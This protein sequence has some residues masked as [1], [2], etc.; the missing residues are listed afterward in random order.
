MEKGE[1]IIV[2]PAYEPNELLV[3][4]VLKLNQYFD[5]EKIIVVDDG[6]K[7]KET[8]AKIKEFENVILLNH[9]ENRGK[10]AAL[11]TAYQ[12]ILQLKD[13]AHIIVTADAD[14]QHRPEDI[15]KV[16]NYYDEIKEGI[17][18]G[19]RL[20]EKK[21]P[22]R[23]RFGNSVTRF[24]FRLGNSQSLQDNQTGLR[25]FGDEL[26]PFMMEISGNRYEYE[27]NVLMECS[28]KN[29]SIH[30]VKIDTVYINNNASS[31]FHPI[32][33]FFK[34]CHNMIKYALPYI[35]SILCDIALFL[36][37]F[38]SL[39]SL[40]IENKWIVLISCFI[41]CV[42]SAIV[43]LLIH[44]LKIFYGN[45]WLL[46]LPKKRVKYL[47]IIL[48]SI[49]TNSF[50]VFGLYELIDNVIHAKVVGELNLLVGILIFNYILVP[51][52]KLR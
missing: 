14:G 6:S 33:D 51:K 19:S 17:V 1:L 3:D 11:K 41:S 31:H 47:F 13:Q 49:F 10:G 38:Y 39:K 4:L 23:S 25:A 43:N 36:L 12:Y 40:K 30:E 32:K 18:L 15:F 48:A 45:Q 50:M 34:I 44:H 46:K 5:N 9:P 52:P 42:L 22:L 21:V 28:R 24:L 27:M 20:F 16:A 2:I 7:N 37:L 8:F 26:L 29:I 35:I